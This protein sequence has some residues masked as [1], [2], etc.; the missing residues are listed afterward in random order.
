MFWILQDVFEGLQLGSEID[1]SLVCFVEFREFFSHFL[2]C[3]CA[4]VADF[5]EELVVVSVLL[6]NAVLLGLE[7]RVYFQLE[8]GNLV[9]EENES[10]AISGVALIDLPDNDGG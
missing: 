2:D 6:L 5:L 4:A 7:L 9:L 1:D 10:L 8:A 3:S